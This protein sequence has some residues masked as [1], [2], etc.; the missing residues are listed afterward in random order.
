GIHKSKNKLGDYMVKSAVTT[1]A[2]VDLIMWLVEPTTFIGAG[3]R[4]IAE[5]LQKAAVPV[6]LVINKTDTLATDKTKT[7]Q[8]RL[9]DC[10]NTYSSIFDFAEIVPV[11]AKKKD[12]TNGLKDVI[13]KYLPYGPMY[14]DEE[15]VTDM[16]EREIVA[17]IIR[18]KALRLLSDEIPHGIAVTIEKMHERVRPETGDSCMDI[19]ATIIC[20]RD[21]HKGIIIGRQG[22]MLKQ[23]GTKSR[24]EIE[25][26][27]DCKTNLKLW[28]KVKK[29]WRDSESLM[30]NYGYDEKNL[31]DV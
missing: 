8:E 28:V 15:S 30:R 1:F 11:S 18:E 27:I 25:K 9:A 20:E 10:I 29:D 3:E 23:I 4:N 17:E 21:S 5:Q 24:I 6:V 12:G 2:D 26:L 22:Q 16:T 13:F 7:K 14:D 19:E 31:G